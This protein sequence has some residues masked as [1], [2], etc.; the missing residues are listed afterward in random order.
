M[1]VDGATAI[2]DREAAVLV[3]VHYSGHAPVGMRHP[4]CPMRKH[5]D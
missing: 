3:P 5:G 1:G 2:V 4:A